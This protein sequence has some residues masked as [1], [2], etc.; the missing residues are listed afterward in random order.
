MKILGPHLSIE[1][2]KFF[3][4]ILFPFFFVFILFTIKLVEELEGVSLVKYGAIPHSSDGLLRIFTFPFIHKD[5]GHL[6]GNATSLIALG[7]VL[8]YFYS[9]KAYQVF[10]M[11]WVLSGLGIWLGGRESYHIGAS[12]LVYGL[13]LFLLVGSVFHRSKQMAAVALLVVL[14]YGGFIWGMIPIMPNLP[15]SW[16]VHLW[17]AISGIVAALFYGR[18]EVSGIHQEPIYSFEEEEEDDLNEDRYWEIPPDDD[19]TK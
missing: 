6:F 7:I 13:I 2:R 9:K 4:S 19:E 5:W 3:H 17:G 8:F 12:G 15:Y 14:F 18:S 11:I 1:V 16:E 10:S